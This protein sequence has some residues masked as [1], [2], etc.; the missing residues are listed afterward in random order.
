MAIVPIS[1]PI[2]SV[3]SGMIGQIGVGKVFPSIHKISN[4]LGW[5]GSVGIIGEG[6]YGRSI[7]LF[8]INGQCNN[9]GLFSDSWD[10]SAFSEVVK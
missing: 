2:N 10:A 1:Y 5:M 9:A 6:D 8:I 7:K 3:R 4:C